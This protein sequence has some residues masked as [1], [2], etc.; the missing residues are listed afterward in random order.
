MLET[1]VGDQA[2][3]GDLQNSPEEKSRGSVMGGDGGRLHRH[4][5]VSTAPRQQ[6]HGKHEPSSTGQRKWDEP[7]LVFFQQIST[8]GFSF[9]EGLAIISIE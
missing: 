8:F 5:G 4:G 3:G 6:G 7:P 9:G 1:G 2:R